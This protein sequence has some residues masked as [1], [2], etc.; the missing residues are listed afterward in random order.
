MTIFDIEVAT[1]D[2]QTRQYR[3]QRYELIKDPAPE[4][5]RIRKIK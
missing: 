3:L 5:F 1:L 2:L 4:Y